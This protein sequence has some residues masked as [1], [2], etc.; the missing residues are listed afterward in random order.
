MELQFW[1][2]S[3]LNYDYLKLPNNQK[4]MASILIAEPEMLYDASEKGLNTWKSLKPL[5]IEEILTKSKTDL[6]LQ[7]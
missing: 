3:D 7:D 6:N 1:N 5:T 2:L 4:K